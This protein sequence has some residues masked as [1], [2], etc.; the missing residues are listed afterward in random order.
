MMRV[1]AQNNFEN[2]HARPPGYR[3]TNCRCLEKTCKSPLAPLGGILIAL[4]VVIAMIC[5]T[6]VEP[7]SLASSSAKDV[8]VST[9]SSVTARTKLQAR[10]VL[11][12]SQ[13]LFL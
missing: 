5:D 2:P 10:L 3:R 4:I 11:K 9:D 12:S 1:K 6:S 13:T 8:L 7:T